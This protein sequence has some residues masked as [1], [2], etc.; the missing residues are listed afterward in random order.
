MCHH[1]PNNSQ[2]PKP[3]DIRGSHLELM[4]ALASRFHRSVVS[5]ARRPNVAACVSMLRIPGKEGG[6]VTGTY[7]DCPPSSD[8]VKKN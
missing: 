4:Q 3:A 7:T 5:C 1:A 2:S 6:F 8:P